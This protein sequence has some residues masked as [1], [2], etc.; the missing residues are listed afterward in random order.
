M[1]LHY[2]TVGK[3]KPIMILHGLFGSGRNWS[4]IANAFSA[5]HEV[6]LVDLRNHGKSPHSSSMSYEQMAQDVSSLIM[7]RGL[8]ELTLIGHSMG[9]KVAMKLAL[10]TPTLIGR[11]IVVDI[12]PVS[13]LDTYTKM[14]TEIYHMPKAAL[15]SRSI[16]NKYLTSSIP[17]TLTRKFILQNLVFANGKLNWRFNVAALLKEMPKIV[18]WPR[19]EETAFPKPTSFI[20]GER[21]ER[22]NGNNERSINAYFPLN[23][24]Y[25]VAGGGHWPHTEAPA[26]FIKILNTIDEKYE[27]SGCF[28]NC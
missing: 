26:E 23:R 14:L 3:G 19:I 18:A 7:R 13:Y 8:K 9:G 12:A 15:L 28:L 27:Q 20:S 10:S 25:I 6:Y 5:E 11:L 2:S 4:S 16:A 24:K 21:S 17:D 22:I 1:D